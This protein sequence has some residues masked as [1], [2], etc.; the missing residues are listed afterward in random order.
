MFYVTELILFFV[1]LFLVLASFSDIKTRTISN[2]LIL[3]FLVFGI[4]YN[5]TFALVSKNYSLL[6]TLLYSIIISLVFFLVL[7]ELGVIAGGDTKLFIAISA[8]IPTMQGTLGLFDIGIGKIE[9]L[10][11]F[12]LILFVTSAFM[13]LPWILIYSKYLL[14]KKKH[15]KALINETFS[16]KN[17]ILLLDSIMVVVLVNLLI[18]LLNITNIIFIFAISFVLTFLIFRI[19]IKLRFYYV[20]LG[21]Y[22]IIF[23]ILFST[24][25]L[26]IDL[27][28]TLLDVSVF[29]IFISI[30]L[31]YLRYIKEKVL[32]ET[33]AIAELKEG[34]LPVYNYYYI[35]KKI[36][37]KKPKFLNKIKEMALGTYY[38]GL[39]IDSSKAC[40]LSRED[41]TFLKDM[42]NNR[43]VENTIYLKKTLSFT[44]A[45]LLA[46]ML[47]IIF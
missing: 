26:T 33:K 6:L 25:K 34:D 29:V 40:G 31:I 19:K 18:S 20:I 42:Y 7:W 17:L 13:V 27:L 16:R 10:P 36:I 12:S 45:V 47:L 21:L 2:K 30:L 39:K 41:I 15:Y 37:L 38:K 1:F 35:N 14:F 28:I 24:H 43:L 46:Y 9:V 32:L 11:I 4:S 3:F 8:I 23:A 44:P 5:I 22:L